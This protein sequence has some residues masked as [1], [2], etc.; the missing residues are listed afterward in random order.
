MVECGCNVVPVQELGYFF[1]FFPVACV[2]NA[3]T[4]YPLQ[5]VQ[6]FAFFVFRVADNI[7]Q[8]LPLE[9]H[10]EYILLAELESL[11]DVLDHFRSGCGRQGNDGNS[12]KQLPDVSYFQVSR[13]EIVSP[14]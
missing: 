9:T 2:N 6:H 14:L 7:G 5:D 4:I 12:R 10:A 1:G 3:G 8:I 11:L 13:A